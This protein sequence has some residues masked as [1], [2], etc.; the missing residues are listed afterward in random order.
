MQTP[1]MSGKA[2]Q[3]VERDGGADHLGEVARGDRD[4]AQH[5]QHE[6]GRPRVAVAAR[7]R[8]VAAA[9]DAEAHRQRLQ[10]DGHQVGD[11]DDA[12]ERVAVARAAGEVGGPV[13]RVHVADG[14][15]VAR[16]GKR[17]E[18]APEAGARRAPRS[19]R[20]LPGGWERPGG[21]ASRVGRLKCLMSD[22]H[23]DESKLCCSRVKSQVTLPSKMLPSS[24]VENYLKAIYQGA[25]TLDAAPTAAA[26]GPAGVGARRGAGHRH[27][28]G[29]G[30]R[31]VRA[32]R[33]R[34]LL[35]R[36]AHARRGTSSPR[37]CCGAT[38]SWSSSS[39]GSWATPGTRCTTRPNSSSTSSRIG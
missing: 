1:Q 27:H 32:G 35:G 14:H 21:C 36:R 34:A 2:E 15:Q 5:P 23:F 10:Q 33:V 12:E 9:A 19:N 31:R 38:G 13:A 3:Q 8:Q 11:E 18:L 37:S 16:A 28:H 22:R 30:A 29:Q 7:L 25:G 20:G 39:C 17:E 6:R 24:T 26:D 4:L